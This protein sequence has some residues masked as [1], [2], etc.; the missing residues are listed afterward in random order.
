MLKTKCNTSPPK[1]PLVVMFISN[2]P[3]QFI[4]LDTAYL[5]KDASGYKYIL[6]IGDIFSKFVDAIPLKDQAV[7]TIVEALLRHCIYIHD[8]PFYL[9]A[10][11]GSN[12]DGEIMNK[13]CENLGIERRRSSAYH[14]Q[15]N[16]FVERN[17]R[18]IKDML[19][20]VLYHRR[21]Q[22]TKWRSILPLLVSA[23]NTSESKA[24]RCV[25]TA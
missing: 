11:Q 23:L 15:G 2:A 4:T 22:Q 7:P 24:T 19:Q 5:P 21:L 14:N 9:L 18:S 20:A 17:I 6:L 8:N 1:A 3:M 16:G 10:D 13:I 25:P 12:V